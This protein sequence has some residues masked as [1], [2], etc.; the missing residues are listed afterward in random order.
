MKS[1]RLENTGKRGWF[2][3]GFPEAAFETDDVEVCYCIEEAGSGIKHYHTKC[4]EIILIISG[5]AMCQ[6]NIYVDGDILIFEPGD[7]NDMVYIDKTIMI[8]LKVPAGKDDK[9]LV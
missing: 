4:T 6:G 2:V 5:K 3:G 9:V 8:G 1:V 7:I